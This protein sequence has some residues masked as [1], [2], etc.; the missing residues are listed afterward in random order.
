MVSDNAG[1]E[2]LISLNECKKVFIQRDY[3]KGLTVKFCAD[4]PLEFEGKID[5]NTWTSFINQLNELYLVADSVT[6]ASIVETV[7]GFLSCYTSRLC[8]RPKWEE[9]LER[10][11]EMIQE[12]NQEVFVPRCLHVRN[13]IEKG[14][15]V[16]EITLLDEP[17]PPPAPV[18][19]NTQPVLQPR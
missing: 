6:P 5:S 15:R 16:I 2:R 17:L 11:E 3:S 14:F 18:I 9:A 8:F 4:F 7:V 12:H 19:N 10:I 1:T 13:P